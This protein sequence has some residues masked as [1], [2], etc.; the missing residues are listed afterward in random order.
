M[1][2]RSTYQDGIIRMPTLFSIRDLLEQ[3]AEMIRSSEKLR[4]LDGHP[5]SALHQFVLDHGREYGAQRRPKGFRRM[6]AKACFGNAYL[7]ATEHGL[8]YVEGFAAGTHRDGPRVAFHHAWC[9]DPSLRV[10][11][12]TLVDPEEY[13]Y[14]GVPIRISVVR[15]RML[16]M[17]A[18]S[19]IVTSTLA[20]DGL[21][22]PFDEGEDII[23]ARRTTSFANKMTEPRDQRHA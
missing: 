14:F 15:K 10:I 17:Q 13:V 16:K 3:E 11:D 22:V 23:D 21:F 6:A 20:P 12:T 1:S 7:K 4:G 19:V 8:I 2:L 18:R 9:L 5:L